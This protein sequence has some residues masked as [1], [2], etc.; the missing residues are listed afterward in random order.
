M[1]RIRKRQLAFAA[2]LLSVSL[3]AL[4]PGITLADRKQQQ[5]GT[6]SINASGQAL[7]IGNGNGNGKGN[8]NN[9][10]SSATL[11]LT[12]TLFSDGS[13]MK[14]GGISGSLQI[15]STTYPFSG[16]EGEGNNKGQLEI[17][18]KTGGGQHGMEL[19]LHGNMQ[20]SNVAFT[21]PQSKL[22]SLF[23]LSLNGQVSVNLSIISPSQGGAQTVTVT[24]TITQ[25]NTV[26]STQN[27]TSIQTVTVNNTQTV[28]ETTVTQTNNSTITETVTQPGT[29]STI[30]ETITQPGTN[31]T[32]TETITTTVANTTITATTTVANTT[33]TTT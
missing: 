23:F 1:Q 16:G 28:T 24:Q 19:V 26:T 27:V 29:N 2:L 14:I 6:I 15:G 11:S 12:G 10:P 8:H 32:I 3:L 9:S 21:Q 18:T 4:Q 25:N 31:S 17:Q 33:I 22:A 5:Q 30:T 13:E 20:G 7:P